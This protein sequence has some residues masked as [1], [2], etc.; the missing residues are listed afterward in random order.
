MTLPLWLPGYRVIAWRWNDSN[1]H[2]NKVDYWWKPEGKEE[3]ETGNIPHKNK[4]SRIHG[5]I[6]KKQTCSVFCSTWTPEEIGRRVFS[7]GDFFGGS[8]WKEYLTLC[9]LLFETNSNTITIRCINLLNRY[10]C[11]CKGIAYWKVKVFAL[12]C[13][14][15]VFVILHYFWNEQN[16]ECWNIK[17][18]KHLGPSWQMNL[19]SLLRIDKSD[20]TWKQVLDKNVTQ[21]IEG[22]RVGYKFVKLASTNIISNNNEIPWPYSCSRDNVNGFLAQAQGDSDGERYFSALLARNA[23]KVV[24]LPGIWDTMVLIWRHRN[25]LGFRPQCAA[26]PT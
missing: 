26:W 1:V 9:S 20:L 6:I 23:V 5:I 7:L 4:N 16:F 22:S 19:I 21:I 14:W 12:L 24:S 15:Y 13:Q 10:A 3:C 18:S 11:E 25:G 8:G 2:S 17:L